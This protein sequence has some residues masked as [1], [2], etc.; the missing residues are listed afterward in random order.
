[1]NRARAGAVADRRISRTWSAPLPD[2]AGLDRWLLRA[3]ASLSQRA[4]LSIA[5]QERVMPA[6]DPFILVANHSTRLESIIL[7]SLLM[8]L[9]GGRPVHFMA[10]WNFMLLPL[11]GRLYR[12]AQVIVVPHKDAR[13]RFLNA[14]RPLFRSDLPPFEQARRHLE[15]GRSVGLFPEGTVNRDRRFLL[16]GRLGAARLSLETG[17][18]VVPVGLRFPLAAADAAIAEGSPMEIEF[19]APLVPEAQ[20]GRPQFVREWHEEVMSAIALRSLKLP[21]TARRNGHESDCTNA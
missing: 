7:P 9:R 5:G 8:L 4:V 12:S 10:D 18:P 11:V 13:P 15:A 14:L 20:A 16:R 6:C 3:V 17:V 21:H 19:G 1:M 2:V